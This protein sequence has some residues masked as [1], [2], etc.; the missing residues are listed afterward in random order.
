MHRG[1]G[2]RWLV[3]ERK[4]KPVKIKGKHHNNKINK[5]YFA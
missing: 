1:G 4:Q 2:R 5:K 3:F